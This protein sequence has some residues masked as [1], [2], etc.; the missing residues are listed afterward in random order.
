MFATFITSKTLIPYSLDMH[1][2]Q[3]RR[4]RNESCMK[5]GQLS[6]AVV[7]NGDQVGLPDEVTMQL[8]KGYVLKNAT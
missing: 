2:V 1:Q 7:V 3:D 6:G 4:L 8:W 5:D